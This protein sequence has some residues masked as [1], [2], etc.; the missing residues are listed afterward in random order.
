MSPQ[1]EYKKKKK[2]SYFKLNKEKNSQ[3]QLFKKKKKN[4]LYCFIYF[5]YR[6]AGEVNGI[7]LTS[8]SYVN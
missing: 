7:A 2:K 8:L 1:Y 3:Y 5:M 6:K 4:T